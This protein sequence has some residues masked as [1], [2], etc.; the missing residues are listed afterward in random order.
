MEILKQCFE[1]VAQLLPPSHQYSEAN[2][3][4]ALIYCLSQHGT[5]QSEVVLPYIF[6][7]QGKPVLFG[8]GRMDIVFEYEGTTHII[9]LKIATKH[10]RLTQFEPQ[11]QRYMTHYKRNYKR[12][13]RG[14]LMCWSRFGCSM[15][16]VKSSEGP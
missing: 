6:E 12:E 9:E 16:E 15:K 2:Y 1:K 4:Q 5:V 10:Y 14:Y 11:I 13:C 7:D 3:Q 8:S